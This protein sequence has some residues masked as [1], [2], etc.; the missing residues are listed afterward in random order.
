MSA[1]TP[2]RGARPRRR[3]RLYES[4]EPEPSVPVSTPASAAAAGDEARA[5]ADRIFPG[6]EVE[7]SRLVKKYVYW[8]TGAG[9]LPLP[10]VG[11]AAVL[12][13]Q[14]KMLSELSRLYRVPFSKQR[15]KALIAALAGGVG[16]AAIG[17]PVAAHV[18]SA[19]FPPS[20]PVLPAACATTASAV[21][22]AMG[23]VF[24]HHFELG[25][26]LLDF[27]PADTRALFEARLAEAR[28]DRPSGDRRR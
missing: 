21:T 22:Y 19:V 28:G 11:P 8:S 12:G 2:E 20:W 7:A 24:T 5:G 18:L 16:A 15:G 14:L 26:T 4:T 25:G 3:A 13:V 17:W 9:L 10:L 23:R 27:R 1:D 6:K